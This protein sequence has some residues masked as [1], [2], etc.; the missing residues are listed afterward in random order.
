MALECE[1]EEAWL[2]DPRAADM[3]FV[4]RGRALRGTLSEAQERVVDMLAETVD[5]PGALEEGRD[6]RVV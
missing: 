1:E 4:P 5:A 6:Q 2:G 3:K